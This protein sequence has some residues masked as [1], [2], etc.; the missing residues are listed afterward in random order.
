MVTVKPV[1]EDDDDEDEDERR[2]EE[3]WGPLAP[4]VGFMAEVQV[5]PLPIHRFGSLDKFCQ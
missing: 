5:N 1:P 2:L 3:T 4:C